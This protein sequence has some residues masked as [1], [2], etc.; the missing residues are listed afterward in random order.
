MTLNSGHISDVPHSGDISLHA[1]FHYSIGQCCFPGSFVL[2]IRICTH[3]QIR[4]RP[5]GCIRQRMNLAHLV[6]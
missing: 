4:I 2:W 6:P 5:L 1:D 3:L